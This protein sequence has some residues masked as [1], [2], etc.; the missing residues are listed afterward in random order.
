VTF[1]WAILASILGIALLETFLS[2]DNAVVLALIARELEPVQQKKALRYGLLGAIALRLVAVGLATYLIHYQWV[3]ILGGLYLGYLAIRYFIGKK[4]KNKHKDLASDSFWKTVAMIE[5]TDLAFAVDS[6][7]AAVAVSD[8][9]WVV[10]AG[11]LIGVVA[12]RFAAQGMIKLLER[13]PKLESIAYALIAA[14]ALKV[15]YEGAHSFL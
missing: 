8:K 9:Y 7:L 13:F 14:V 1:N 15:I 5:F 12:I 6:I 10:V 11:G 2:I 4:K 3:K